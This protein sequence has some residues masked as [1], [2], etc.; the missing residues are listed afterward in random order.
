MHLLFIRQLKQN[1]FWRWITAQPV[2][3]I[4]V[5]NR[6][7]IKILISLN[8]IDTDVYLPFQSIPMLY[9]IKNTRYEETGCKIKHDIRQQIKEEGRT[10]CK[11]TLSQVC[12]VY[13]SARVFMSQV[14]NKYKDLCRSEV[15]VF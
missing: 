15:A 2:R 12:S 5:S 6:I 9:N 8:I 1:V 3:L 10:H 4:P 11:P 14:L 13:L 7:S